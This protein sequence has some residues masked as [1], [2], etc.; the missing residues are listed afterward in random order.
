MQKGNLVFLML[1]SL[2][3]IYSFDFERNLIDFIT[4]NIYKVTIQNWEVSRLTK[5]V[6]TN[7]FR[8]IDCF[9]EGSP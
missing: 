3:S 6:V 8:G 2:L 9:R 4:K 7:F 1:I 5:Y